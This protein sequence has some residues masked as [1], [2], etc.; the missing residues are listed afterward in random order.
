[1]EPRDDLL[2]LR[3]GELLERLAGDEP[4]PAGGSSA[5][6]SVAMAAAVLA[7]A[8]RAAIGSWT[9]AGGIA[10]QAE[11]LRARCAPLAQADA[12]AFAAGLRALEDEKDDYEL[13]KALS[14]AADVPLAIAEAGADVAALA[15]VVAERGQEARR[16]DAIAAALLAEAGAR[17]AA[18]LVAVNLLSLPGDERAGR[19]E[20]AARNATDAAERALAAR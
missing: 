4:A 8:A 7:K 19:A 14:H 16:G 18:E 5:A 12:D 15:T 13:A 1:M 11:T 10:A 6:V 2:D 3:L 17:A 20:R 9:D